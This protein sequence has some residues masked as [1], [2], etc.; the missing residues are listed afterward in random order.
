MTVL[1]I[2]PAAT[3]VNC[4][5]SPRNC[6]GSDA[7]QTVAANYLCAADVAF[8][9]GVSNASG[10]SSLCCPPGLSDEPGGSCALKNQTSFLCCANGESL[11]G[12]SCCSAGRRCG[13]D[14]A[15]LTECCAAT[16]SDT[17]CV[18]GVGLVCSTGAACCMG[19]SGCD[20]S[21]P[22]RPAGPSSNTWIWATVGLVSVLLLVL[23]VAGLVRL[24]RMRERRESFRP[25]VA[26]HMRLS[27]QTVDP[28]DDVFAG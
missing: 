11:C 1:R 23:A 5:F 14:I 27:L 10:A 13:L 9:S 26:D 12:S 24:R 16:T 28:N 18:G 15:V 6:S 2:D 17:C 4:E 20:S 22:G 8:E 7:C 3:V 21:C 25:A 19:S